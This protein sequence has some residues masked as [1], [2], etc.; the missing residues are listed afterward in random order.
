M[1]TASPHG[2]TEG[3]EHGGEG[4]ERHVDDDAPLVFGFLCHD[5][6]CVFKGLYIEFVRGGCLPARRLKRIARAATLF[7]TRRRRLRAAS[8][9]SH[10]TGGVGR[11]VHRH[12]AILLH[13]KHALGVHHAAQGG[14]LRLTVEEALHLQVVGR[15]SRFGLLDPGVDGRTDGGEAR[16]LAQLRFGPG[17]VGVAEFH[18]VAGAGL[19]VQSGVDVFVSAGASGVF[20][21][22]PVSRYFSHS[23]SPP[24]PQGL[25]VRLPGVGTVRSGINLAAGSTCDVCV[26]LSEIPSAFPYASLM[27]PLAL[28]SPGCVSPRCGVGNA[29]G[30]LAAHT[31]W[32]RLS[33]EISRCKDRVPPLRSKIFP[34]FFTLR[35]AFFFSRVCDDTSSDGPHPRVGA[36]LSCGQLSFGHFSTSHALFRG[37]K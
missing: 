17:R 33:L 26:A 30:D 18:R 24:V 5:S 13:A 27:P 3:R 2:E 31:G 20:A 12:A 36:A 1:R 23:R 16:A 19:P 35:A 7:A 6:V 9:A 8:T 21:G 37:N 34:P 25:M 4:G 14:K 22:N 32:E 11:D 28:C 10:G 15:F 29:R